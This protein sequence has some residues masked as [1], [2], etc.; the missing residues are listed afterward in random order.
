MQCFPN[1]FAT[2][3]TTSVVGIVYCVPSQSFIAFFDIILMLSYGL[4]GFIRRY[5]LKFTY[6]IDVSWFWLLVKYLPI[7]IF[8]FAAWVAAFCKPF[9]FS[10]IDGFL[11]VNLKK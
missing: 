8:T 5:Y 9:I 11:G 3:I 2:L 4:C 1:R 10:I 7:Q 6:A